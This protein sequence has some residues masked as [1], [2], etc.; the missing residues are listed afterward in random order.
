VTSGDAAPERAA[1]ADEVLLPDELGEVAGA[2]PGRERLLL[3]RRLEE[4]LRAGAACFGPGRRH[5][6]SLEGPA[7]ALGRFNDD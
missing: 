1:L 5:A 4:G 3:G 6:L 2:H 7:A